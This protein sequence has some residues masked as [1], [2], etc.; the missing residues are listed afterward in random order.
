MLTIAA[1]LLLGFA[2]GWLVCARLRDGGW[3]LTLTGLVL[4]GY[5]DGRALGMSP[6]EL[7]EI[8]QKARDLPKRP[9]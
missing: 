2:A 3:V 9:T 5:L 6:Q 7:R 8:Q 1:A 4:A